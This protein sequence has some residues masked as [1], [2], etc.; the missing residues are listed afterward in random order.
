MINQSI[1]SLW[2]ILSD[3]RYNPFYLNKEEFDREQ[4][5]QKD[6]VDGIAREF[7][8]QEQEKVLERLSH[9]LDE[10]EKIARNLSE[11]T[12]ALKDMGFSSD[13]GQDR[14]RRVKRA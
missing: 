10:L 13:Y 1:L 2:A 12:K 5:R 3:E 7:A 4:R 8:R 6:M 14:K 11:I 9:S